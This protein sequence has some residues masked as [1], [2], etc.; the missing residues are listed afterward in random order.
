MS[1]ENIS[2]KVQR[3]P[4]ILPYAAHKRARKV[5]GFISYL[6]NISLNVIVEYNDVE[7]ASCQGNIRIK[8]FSNA[9]VGYSKVQMT[10]GHRG[11]K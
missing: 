5:C 1:R 3:K 4:S 8:Y 10:S 2:C 11:R 9:T 6:R 7:L